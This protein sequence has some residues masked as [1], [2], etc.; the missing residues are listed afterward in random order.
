MI[1]PGLKGEVERSVSP[2][3]TAAEHGSGLVPVF[4]T[5]ALV[6]LMESA[7]VQAL[8]GHL[9]SGQTTVGARIDV[10]HLA[11]TPVGMTVRAEA[12]LQEVD[13]RKLVFQVE[14]YDAVEKI[15]SAVHVRYVIDEARFMAHVKMKSGQ[16]N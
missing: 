12:R 3:D 2:Q 11:A 14:A 9:D 1:S 7:A 10:Q 15:G 4:S 13:G 16:E 5:P 6:A 8:A